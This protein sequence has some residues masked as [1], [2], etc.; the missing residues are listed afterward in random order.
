MQT[1]SPLVPFRLPRAPSCEIFTPW[2]VPSTSDAI[3]F[4]VL[5][6]EEKF[7]YRKQFNSLKASL[8]WP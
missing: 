7:L 3:W 5:L 8:P 2:S 6:W 4:P 1:W